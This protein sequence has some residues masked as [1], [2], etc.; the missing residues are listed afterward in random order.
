MPPHAPLQS[1]IG[2]EI[3]LASPYQAD[4][5]SLSAILGLCKCGLHCF[6]TCRE[7][8]SYLRDHT[9]GVMIASASLPDGTWRSLLSELSLSANAPNLIVTSR[10]ADERLWAEVLN[11]GGYDLLVVPYDA[12]EVL[13]ITA[14]AWLDWER[15]RTLRLQKATAVPRGSFDLARRVA[16]TQQHALK[17]PAAYSPGSGSN[18]R[19]DAPGH[20]A[21]ESSRRIS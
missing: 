10:M 5:D 11:M 1:V 16:V 19:E 15:K 9:V 2:L 21:K 7:A 4:H 17:K 3:L 20:Q 18:R 14:Q 13:R 6:R 12:D 8:V